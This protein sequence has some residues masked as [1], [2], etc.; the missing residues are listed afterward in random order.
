MAKYPTQ[1]SSMTNLSNTK[2]NRVTATIRRISFEFAAQ[3]KCKSRKRNID[4]IIRSSPQTT[5]LQSK[6]RH[7]QEFDDK[8]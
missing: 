6:D 1:K 2:Y 8:S 4:R 7:V 3:G 5:V